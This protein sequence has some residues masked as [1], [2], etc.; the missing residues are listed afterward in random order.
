MITPA[1]PSEV[2][3]TSYTPKQIDD[4]VTKY[5]RINI[6]ATEIPLLIMCGNSCNE[7][8]DSRLY[9]SVSK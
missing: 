6:I 3:V 2:R 5:D 4:M 7:V 9:T 1:L 8:D